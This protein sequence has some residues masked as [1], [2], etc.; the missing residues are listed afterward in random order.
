MTKFG[1]NGGLKKKKKKPI[2]IIQKF[3][4]KQNLVN[5][6]AFNSMCHMYWL[7]RPSFDSWV[8]ALPWSAES[9]RWCYPPACEPPPSAVHSGSSPLAPCV[10][11]WLPSCSGPSSAWKERKQNAQTWSENT[12]RTWTEETYTIHT[13]ANRCLYEKQFDLGVAEKRKRQHF[14]S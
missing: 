6:K 11:E 10:S 12:Y 5:G 3:L 9:F 7:T 4:R 1:E 14:L 8:L 13:L 2:L